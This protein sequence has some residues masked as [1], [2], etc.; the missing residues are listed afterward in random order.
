MLPCQRAGFI[1]RFASNQDS[2]GVAALIDGVYREYG[3]SLN[4]NGAD[5]DLLDFRGNYFERGGQFVVLESTDGAI[6]ASHAVLPL[7]SGLGV[8]KRLYLTPS[9]RGAEWGNILMNWAIL[10]SSALD[11][12]KIEFWSD[13]RFHRAHA[14]FE[15]FGF[16]H[17]GRVR[18]MDDG[19]MPYSEKYFSLELDD[20][21]LA[22]PNVFIA[23]GNGL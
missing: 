6:V 11:I 2:D 3:D 23:S 4:L 15:R 5:S 12:R 10:A 20:A 9:L 1:L 16:R 21:I 22:D 17:D 14:F 7:K 18:A 8:F 19:N 13:S